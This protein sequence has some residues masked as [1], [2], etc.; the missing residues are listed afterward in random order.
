MLKT[1][2]F[3]LSLALLSCT[4]LICHT[5][6]LEQSDA[7]KV[8]ARA[9]SDIMLEIHTA[10]TLKEK[11]E[12]HFQEI[13]QDSY[14]TKKQKCLDLLKIIAASP[15]FSSTLEQVTDHQV[16]L[17]VREMALYNNIVID[18][19]LYPLEKKVEAELSLAHFNPQEAQ[20][21]NVLYIVFA[22]IRGT[23]MLIHKLQIVAQQLDAQANPLDT[24]TSS[25]QA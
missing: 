20:L 23:K 24:P 18:P 5:P 14:E 15:E 3:S 1:T 4:P 2:Y 19:S 17:I 13:F 16:Q 10:L 25:S 22:I 8:M 11:A 21:F 12:K 9:K 6:T 7:I